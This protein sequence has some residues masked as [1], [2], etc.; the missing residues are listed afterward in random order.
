MGRWIAG[1][2]VALAGCVGQAAEL[3]PV[4]C[5]GDT[6]VCDGEAVCDGAD[7]YVVCG[8]SGPYCRAFEGYVDGP[9]DA[10]PVCVR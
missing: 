10:E 7:A 4:E 1:L 9:V 2:C 3:V 5:D 6:V 8:R